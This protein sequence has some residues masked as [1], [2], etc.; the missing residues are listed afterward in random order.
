[1]AT[2]VD[3]NGLL[4]LLQPKNPQYAIADAGLTE[5]RKQQTDLCVAPQNLFEFWAVATRPVANNGLGMSLPRIA[6]EIQAM[7]GLFRLLEGKAGI[8]GAWEKLVAPLA[9]PVGI[10]NR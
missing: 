5:L 9:R 3:T 1:M 7:Q 6:G 10:H 2:L 4:R 8:I